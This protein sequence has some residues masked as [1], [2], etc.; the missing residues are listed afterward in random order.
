MSGYFLC[1]KPDSVLHCSL[2][3]IP[4]PIVTNKLLRFSPP[5]FYAE[6]CTE[7]GRGATLHAGK[8][9]AVSLCT[10]P[11]SYPYEYYVRTQAVF[12][13]LTSLLAPLVIL[14]WTGVTRYLF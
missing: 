14:H 13:T 12:T 4:G 8:D 10:L 1:D 7:V 2:S 5:Y 11:Y 3:H 6:H 9:L